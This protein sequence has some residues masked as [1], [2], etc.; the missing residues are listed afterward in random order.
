[1]SIFSNQIQIDQFVKKPIGQNMNIR[2]S[3]PPPNS[4]S[5]YGPAFSREKKRFA[6]NILADIFP[7]F[8]NTSACVIPFTALLL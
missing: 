8:P 6:P 2:I 1:M 4:R 7:P 5:S 3:P